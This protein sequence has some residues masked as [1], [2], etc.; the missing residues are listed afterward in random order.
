MCFTVFSIVVPPPTPREAVKPT[1]C[2]HIEKKLHTRS[3]KLNLTIFML[4]ILNSYSYINYVDCG[5]F[6]LEKKTSFKTM[7]IRFTKIVSCHVKNED[8]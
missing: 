1:I 8:V 4:S 5:V 7:H 6:F 2:G 3:I